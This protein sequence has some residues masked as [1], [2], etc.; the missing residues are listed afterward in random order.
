LLSSGWHRQATSLL[1]LHT[2]SGA[3][4]RYDLARQPSYHRPSAAAAAVPADS[5]NV[6]AP[7]T[8]VSTAPS[9]TASRA[10]WTIGQDP[11]PYRPHKAAFRSHQRLPILSVQLLHSTR[12]WGF[13]IRLVAASSD[14][15]LAPNTSVSTAPSGTA[16]RRSRT[17]LQLRAQLHIPLSCP[18]TA[19]LQVSIMIWHPTQVLVPPQVKL[20]LVEV[21][22]YPK[23]Q[24]T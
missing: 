9:G 8:S 1:V 4:Y 12:S 7:N 22:P 10:S 21:S 19:L 17:V 20:R 3:L 6:L 5:D 14:N 16:S 23:A 2:T 24:S 18:P 11:A 13:T 15:V